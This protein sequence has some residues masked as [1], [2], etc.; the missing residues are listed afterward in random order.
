[1]SL[2]IRQIFLMEMPFMLLRKNTKNYLLSY[3]ATSIFKHSKRGEADY[4]QYSERCSE[5]A[6]LSVGPFWTWAGLL[7]GRLKCV[8]MKPQ[9]QRL[10]MAVFLGCILILS[11]IT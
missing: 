2:P 7:R 11:S 8:L 9:S 4:Q 1:M 5:D 3:R 10:F 6:L